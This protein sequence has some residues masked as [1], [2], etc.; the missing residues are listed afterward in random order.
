MRR[1]AWRSSAAGLAVVAFA[2]GCNGSATVSQI[3]V[4]EASEAVAREQVDIARFCLTTSHRCEATDAW[5][6]AIAAARCEQY[7]ERGDEMPEECR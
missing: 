1:R 2:A 6:D 7:A 3:R 4:P 5:H